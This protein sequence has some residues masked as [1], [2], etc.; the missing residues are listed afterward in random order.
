MNK[1]GDFSIGGLAP[2]TYLVW[3]EV[4]NSSIY[5]RSIE[6]PITVVPDTVAEIQ[7]PIGVRA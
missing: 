7:I 2:G 1:D 5:T 3:A 4:Y 6:I